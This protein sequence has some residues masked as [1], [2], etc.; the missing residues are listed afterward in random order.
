MYRTTA[1]ALS[2]TPQAEGTCTYRLVRSLRCEV[3]CSAVS[4][5]RFSQLGTAFGFRC[6]FS[7]D[8]S[9]LSRKRRVVLA[10]FLLAVGSPS[11]FSREHGRAPAAAVKLRNSFADSLSRSLGKSAAAGPLGG[12]GR[13]RRRSGSSE[14]RWKRSLSREAVQPVGSRLRAVGSS[15][16]EAAFS[17]SLSYT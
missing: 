9:D 11:V 15:P 6:A 10:A 2:W 4:V 7:A 1:C 13:A 16:V 8:R 14:A 17:L 3:V 12:G 5:E